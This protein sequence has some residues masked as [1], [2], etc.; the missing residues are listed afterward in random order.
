MRALQGFALGAAMAVMPALAGTPLPDGPHVVVSGEGQASVAPDR[1][2]LRMSADALD[3]TPAGAKQRVDDAVNRYLAILE[4]RGVP[5]ADVTASSLQLN[6]EVDRDDDGRRQSRG[7]RA[8]RDVTARLAVA[9]FNEVIDAGLAAG[10]TDIDEI[11]FVSSRAD[12]MRAEAR[13]RAATAS[14]ARAEALARA[15]GARLG[16]IYSINSINSGLGNGYGGLDRVEV[17]GARAPSRYLQPKIDFTERVQVV[18][19]LIP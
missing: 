11:S 3:A 17:T 7:H 18:F 8:S 12:A 4:K 14:R 10:M 5:V 19:E 1:V 13:E 16:R 6:E 9:G 2:V 15:Y